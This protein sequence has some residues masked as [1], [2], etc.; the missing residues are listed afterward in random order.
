MDEE[1]ATTY[2]NALRR[3]GLR[4][5]PQR[6]AICRA[7]VNG[8]GHP[9]AAEL[10]KQ[11]CADF[12]TLSLATVYTT[13][14]TLLA[15]GVIYDLGD[16]GDGTTHYDAITDPHINLICTR[17]H[18]ISDLTD[19]QL[20]AIRQHVAQRSGYQI[21]GARIAYYGVCPKCASLT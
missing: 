12:P 7:L 21:L 2:I 3:A 16:A 11:L 5:T 9:T 8:H 1:R 18:Q 13:L 20:E 6:L 19:D 17:C 4:L 10:H 14:N 15:L